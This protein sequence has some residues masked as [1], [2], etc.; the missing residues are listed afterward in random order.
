[1]CTHFIY[2]FLCLCIHVHCTCTV[3]V[4]LLLYTKY[5]WI[6]VPNTCIRM[7]MYTACIYIYVSVYHAFFQLLPPSILSSNPHS[8]SSLLVQRLLHQFSRAFLVTPPDPTMSSSRHPPSPQPG[9]EQVSLKEFLQ[10]EMTVLLLL[11][12]QTI[13][14]Q[15]RV[16]EVSSK[17]M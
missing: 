16:S 17:L 14:R 13:S 9:M 1:M 12:I 8:V 6:P 10:E 7:Y 4:L 11:S 3:Q 5:R 2:T 15:V